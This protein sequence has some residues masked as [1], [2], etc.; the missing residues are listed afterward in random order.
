ME[1]TIT[2]TLTPSQADL[3]RAGLA[4]HSN[5]LQNTYTKDKAAAKSQI[6]QCR[7]LSLLIGS[8]TIRQLLKEQS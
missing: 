3:L 6:A 7:E 1:T 5:L 2:I 4:A 8:E